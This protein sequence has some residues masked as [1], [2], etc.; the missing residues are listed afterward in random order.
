MKTNKII[1][2][3]VVLAIV[4]FIVSLFMPALNKAKESARFAVESAN[5]RM[6]NELS[7]AELHELASSDGVINVDADE[8]WVIQ[9]TDISEGSFR[10]DV[11]VPLSGSCIAKVPDQKEEV[12]L[13]LKHTDVNGN[14]S[15]YIATVEVRQKFHNPYAV[16]IEAKYV[17][18]LPQNAAVND[19]LMTIGDRTIR[20][21]IREKEEAKK[22]Y[23]QARG[24]GYTASLLTQQRPNIFTQKVANIE[25]GKAIDINIKYFN[26]LA[27]KDGWYE[28][29]FPMV[30]GP[31]FNP[32]HTTDG[33]AAVAH[34]TPDGTS[35]QSSEV[36]YLKPDQ[37]SGHD[38]SLAVNIDAGVKI[39][40]LVCSSHIIEKKY[41]SDSRVNVQ[42]ARNDTIPNKD[43]VLRYNVA[44]DKVK[45][46]IMTTSD[47]N[48]S[49][50][51]MM[52]YP[53]ESITQLKRVPM[54][55]IFV[56]DCSGSMNGWPM[57]IS[58]QA[59]SRALK[60]LGPDDSFQ[61][62]QFS[63][64]ASRLG[65][66]PVIAS[67]ENINIGLKYVKQLNVSGGT[68]M[69]EGIKAALDF[70]H[71]PKRFRIVSFMTDGYIGNEAEILKAIS[72]KLGESRI[73]SFGIGSSPNRYLLDRMAA[74]GQGAVSYIGHNDSP[75]EPVDNFYET[76]AHPALTDI[77]INFG[78]MQ[79]AEVWPQK[80]PDLF[81][82]RAVV[83]TGK[84]KNTKKCNITVSGRVGS[85]D[86]EYTVPAEFSDNTRHDGIAA[87]WARKKIE[88][89]NNKLVISG[90]DSIASEILVT[91][92][93]YN[94]MSDLT[95]F[96][97]VDSTAQTSGDYGVSVNV[98]E[99][100]PEGVKYETTVN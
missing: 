82:G 29:V 58:K 19:F 30:V 61:I 96:V 84:C 67:K 27:Y 75:V 90:N 32:P 57:D 41:N 91:A 38:I 89:L 34:G 48:G 4:A 77:S 25:P 2:L 72:E 87:I 22:I 59:I 49:Y 15:G 99:L 42:I 66:K 14:V 26:T 24:L 70:E 93:N 44:G 45:T 97:A 76:I 7:D 63:N 86:Q 9:K 95:S 20:G 85:L 55:M 92:L 17:F 53:P 62:I 35:S 11:D 13:P 10:C 81:A 8:I 6:L 40:D 74:I 73:F 52:L 5:R 18:P 23:E 16:K 68:M 3:L 56:L 79:V 94:L 98:P 28:F 33:V 50:F 100:M 1:W 47:E 43:F 88:M 39:E 12:P 69:I 78:D 71:D 54:E 60:R 64:N 31:R 83:I 37:R 36:H 51:T 80:V 46:G 65:S 21:V